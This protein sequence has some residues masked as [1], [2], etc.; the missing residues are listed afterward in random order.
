MVWI[1]RLAVLALALVLGYAALVLVLGRI[2]DPE[3]LATWLEP[4]AEAALNRDVQI[5]RVGITWLPF[6]V[7][8]GALEV[9]DPSGIR[10]HLVRAEAVDLR[11]ALLP[12]LGRTVRVERVTV[13]APELDLHLDSEGRS[14][15]EGLGSRD[16]AEPADSTAA[17]FQVDVRRVR[18]TDGTVAWTDVRQGRAASVEG[19]DAD[20][21]VDLD[22]GSTGIR[23]QVDATLGFATRELSRT[24][25]ATEAR[26]DALLDRN[27]DRLD[28]RGLVLALEGLQ[29]E[30]S[31]SVTDLGDSVR[32]LDL[33]VGAQNIDAAAVLDLLPDSVRARIGSAFGRADAEFRLSG[34]AGPGVTPGL[35]GRLRVRDGGWETVSGDRVLDAVEGTLTAARSDRLEP[36]FR[37]RV[38]GGEAR[39]DGAVTLGD[40]GRF[41]LNVSADVALPDVSARLTLPDGM[42]LDGRVT[43]DVRV[44]GPTADPAAFALE[45]ALAG[46]DIQ[47]RHAALA[48]PVVVSRTRLLLSGRDARVEPTVIRLSG[49]PVTVEGSARG[50]G[51]LVDAQRNVQVTASLRGPRLDLVRLMAEPPA[52][53]ALTYGRVAFARLGNRE[54]QGRTPEEAAQAMGLSRPDSL[55]FA[56]TVAVALDTLIDRRGRSVDLDADVEFGP[57]FIQVR[58]AEFGRYGGRIRTRADL[59]LGGAPDEPFALRLTAT[60]VRAADFLGATTP[61]GRIVRG[62]ITV[63]L[64]VTGAL[65]ALLLPGRRSLV[66]T[67]RLHLRDGGLARNPVTERLGEFLGWERLVEP[68]IQDWQTTFLLEDGTFIFDEATMVGA[69][70]TPHLSGRVGPDGLIEMLAAFALPTERV[71]AGALRR[72]GVPESV[73][74]ELAERQGLVQ[75][76]LRIAGNVRNPVLSAEPDGSPAASLADQVEEEAREEIR[77][78]VDE[79][80]GRLEERASGFLRGL[81]RRADSAGAARDSVLPDTA[82]ADTTRVDTLSVPA[83]ADSV[84][85]DSIGG[86]ATGRPGTFPESTSS[87]LPD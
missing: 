26:V 64:D 74:A 63:D 61:L 73:A 3:R 66:G 65:D 72:I 42:G 50:L 51:A 62:T 78:R 7:R 45:G 19:L 76:L 8:L 13:R 17:T 12:L 18:V 67:G 27:A 58:Q 77:E 44:V 48:D 23:G 55:P 21:D 34:P 38:P 11:I 84:S 16:A 60:D 56:G 20:F 2:L 81:I 68:V 52:D 36:S 22:A 59:A 47:V 1:R 28:L 49:D 54:V 10:P 30:L 43:A 80:R 24:G 14:T 37:A 69:P 57:R 6:G 41:D 87:P 53:T 33:T 71:G 25:L 5:E 40:S 31:G 85:R 32:T 35:D 15:F 75:A 82:R 70:G 9:G 39:V 79:Q 46:E 29:A 83:P 4:R 86:N